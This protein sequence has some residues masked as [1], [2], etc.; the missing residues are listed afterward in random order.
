MKQARTLFEHL[1][2]WSSWIGNNRPCPFIDIPINIF[3][4]NKVSGQLEPS[5]TVWLSLPPLI[6]VV[7]WMYILELAPPASS[8][9]STQT[10][11][12]SDCS[13]APSLPAYVSIPLLL[14][15]FIRVF[16]LWS[17]PC[18]A[19]DV[20]VSD[21]RL[22]CMVL[23]PPFT[24]LR[25]LDISLPRFIYSFLLFRAEI[26]LQACGGFSVWCV[27]FSVLVSPRLPSVSRPAWHQP[28]IPA[29]HPGTHKTKAVMF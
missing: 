7:R 15:F 4:E 8:M 14:L 27:V 29:S 16:V 12:V 23:L 25:H 10:H 6:R 13:T 3:G 28:R 22:T 17:P 19:S 1:I 11:R 5:Q 2:T 26:F 9:T 18:D 24:F 20:G 21:A